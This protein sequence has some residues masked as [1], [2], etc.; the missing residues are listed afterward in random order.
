M[1]G[2]SLPNRLRHLALVAL[3]GLVVAGCAEDAP[4]DT[5]EPEGGPARDIDGLFNLVF[6]VGAAVFVFVMAAVLIVS[7]RYRARRG[8]DGQWDDDGELPEQVHGNTR[9]ELGWTILP[10]LILAV[11]AV[12]TL[13][14]VFTLQDWADDADVEI[15]VYGAQWWWEFRYPGT[16]VVTANTIVFPAG[17]PIEL[18][19]TSYDVIH[20]FWIPA[21]NGKRDVAPGRVHEWSL[22]ADEPGTYWGQCAEFCGLSH[23]YMR[24]RAVALAPDDYDRWLESQGGTQPGDGPVADDSYLETVRWQQTRGVDPEAAQRGWETFGQL[25]SSCHV[26]RGQFEAAEGGVAPLVSGHAPDLTH[27]MTRTGFAA[28]IY[29]LY[30]ADG[31]VNVSELRN[32]VWDAPSMK[33]MAPDDLRGM[34]SFT[35]LLS[36]EAVDDVV[37]YLMTLGDEPTLPAGE[38]LGEADILRRE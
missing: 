6:Y 5:L 7:L 16:D 31:S 28:N 37:A 26:V 19:M 24:I 25:C 34:P 38:T 29:D 32:W 35:E 23:A 20:S 14:T 17:E 18:T 21:L 4:Y 11:I 15:E 8:R 36:R 33:A 27:L 22:Q 12:P 1:T 9:L 2:R 3:V 13:G 10:A 30:E